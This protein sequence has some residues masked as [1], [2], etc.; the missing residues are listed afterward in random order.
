MMLEPKQIT[1]IVDTDTTETLRHAATMLRALG[2][3]LPIA[4]A[5]ARLHLRCEA[6][7]LAQLARVIEREMGN[8]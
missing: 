6:R 5:E 7:E 4:L 2:E 8:G 3:I 1:L